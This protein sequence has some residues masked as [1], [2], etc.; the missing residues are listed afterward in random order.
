MKVLSGRNIYTYFNTILVIHMEYKMQSD[1]FLA[2]KL[3][4]TRKMKY[5]TLMTSH[6]SVANAKRFLLQN[7]TDVADV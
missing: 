4:F 5:P 7:V 3:N 1:K 6:S 2:E